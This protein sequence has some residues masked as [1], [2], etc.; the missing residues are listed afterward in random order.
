[1][2]LTGFCG[3]A[4]MDAQLPRAFVEPEAGQVHA[5]GYGRPSPSLEQ[6]DGDG[7]CST[8]C[9]RVAFVACIG[10]ALLV[11]RGY[12]THCRWQ[13]SR[14]GNAALSICMSPRRRNAP[15][16]PS[17]SSVFTNVLDDDDWMKEL[18]SF[19]KAKSNPLPVSKCQASLAYSATRSRLVRGPSLLESRSPTFQPAAEDSDD[20]GLDFGK[21]KSMPMPQCPGRRVLWRPCCTAR[22]ATRRPSAPPMSCPPPSPPARALAPGPCR[23]GQASRLSLSRPC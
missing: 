14:V 16:I 8:F 5:A 12:A 6:G 7:D 20:E 2:L 15:A 13:R 19:G 10:C 9:G 11:G 21:A 1:M 22:T 18:Q 23:A 3:L 4:F 17:I